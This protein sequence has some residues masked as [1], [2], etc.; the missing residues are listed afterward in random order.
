MAEASPETHPLPYAG[1]A[2]RPP[3]SRRLVVLV[4]VNGLVAVASLWFVPLAVHIYSCTAVKWCHLQAFVF[5]V[6][7]GLAWVVLLVVTASM[8][9]DPEPIAARSKPLKI[10]AWLLL[11]FAAVVLVALFGAVA[12]SSR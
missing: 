3:C 11:C 9:C 7:S 10:A 5:G 4:L 6:P 2:T 12:H 8:T 1:P